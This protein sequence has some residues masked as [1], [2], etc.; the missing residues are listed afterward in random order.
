MEEVIPEVYTSNTNDSLSELSTLL[1]N[2]SNSKPL[3][4]TTLSLT[5]MKVDTKDNSKLT[6]SITKKKEGYKHG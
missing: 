5:L 3:T 4:S 1:T 6:N 2:I